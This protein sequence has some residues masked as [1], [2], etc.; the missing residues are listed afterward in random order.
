[1]LEGLILREERIGR[2][3]LI[4]ADCL[5]LLPLLGRFDAVVTDPPYGIG[6]A[7]GASAGGTD[8]SG[9]YI[10]KPRRYAGAWDNE[11]A[12]PEAIA[13]LLKCADLHIIWGGN[14]FTDLLP[15]GGV[16]LVW[17]KLNSMPTYSDGEL[18]WTSVKGGSV[19][20]W[21]RCASGLSA[22][23]DGRVHPTQKPIDLM[24]WCLDF[25]PMTTTIL[26][27][28][29]GSATTLVACEHTGRSGTGIE[30]DP[31]HF[32]AAC[33]KVREAANEIA[34]G[35]AADKLQGVLL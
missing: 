28:Y 25:L 32:E 19:K 3:R 30:R 4:L 12:A 8:G 20:K 35:F 23:R 24:K 33:Q 16:W 2:Q 13:A 34:V 9:K 18:A 5:P 1:M 21:T 7:N 10:R 29:M 26:D 14:F 17:D 6:K 31:D 15:L 27:P 11:R 22:N